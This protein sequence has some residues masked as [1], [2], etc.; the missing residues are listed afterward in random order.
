MKPGRNKTDKELQSEM[1]GGKNYDPANPKG[2]G[3]SSV[4]PAPNPD[5]QIRWIKK[6]INANIE[7]VHNPKDPATGEV[8][9]G[10][11]QIIRYQQPEKGDPIPPKYDL[12]SEGNNINFDDLNMFDYNN[13][14]LDNR[15]VKK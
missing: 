5:Q 3:E 2:S 7:V 8:Q 1:P 4:K 6:N 11:Y 9:N 13:M 10:F 12:I 15:M 14:K